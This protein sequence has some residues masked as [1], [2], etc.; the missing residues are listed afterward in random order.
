MVGFHRL[1]WGGLMMHRLYRIWSQ[2]RRCFGWEK[3]MKEK[4]KGFQLVFFLKG[5]D[6]FLSFMGMSSS[7]DEIETIN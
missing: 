7:R 3:F 1:G 4:M 6:S 2:V 5:K